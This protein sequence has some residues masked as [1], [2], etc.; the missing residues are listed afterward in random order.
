MR[1][2]RSLVC[3]ILLSLG[4]VQVAVSQR[5]VEVVTLGWAVD[6]TE[7][8]V[9]GIVRTLLAYFRLPHPGRT[10]TAL[11]SA[12]EQARFPYYDLTADLLYQGFPATIVEVTPAAADSSLW[13]A[14]T[15][16]ARAD[17]GGTNIQPLG[18]QRLYAQRS[19]DG[20]QLGSALPVLT[21]RWRVQRVGGLVY[22]YDPSTSLDRGRARLADLFIDS[23]AA[24][25]GVARPPHVDYYLATSFEAV[26]RLQGLDWAL[27]RAMVGGQ[28]IPE[29]S[30]LFSG[31]PAFGEAFTHELVHLVLA[32]YGSARTRHRF[33]EEGVAT[34]LG[35]GSR[36]PHYRA[37]VQLLVRYQAA[38]PDSTLRDLLSVF[39]GDDSPFYASG[40]LVADAVFRRYGQDGIR[41]LLAIGPSNDVLFAVLP[42][43]L[44]IGPDSLE[45]WWRAQ[46]SRVLTQSSRQGQRPS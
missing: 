11:W 37:Y 39:G 44:G 33:V 34:W 27:N 38:H 6:T 10:H 1:M 2:V 15:L 24:V 19:A 36:D 41:R 12:T 32:A 23:V 35:G 17:S 14:K 31:A 46:P 4:S 30:L 28:A 21:R 16:F 22:H 42:G 18:L 8:P 20:W 13:V 26:R 5:P 3:G 43:L 45:Q 7:G 9:R 29:D 40:A 25:L